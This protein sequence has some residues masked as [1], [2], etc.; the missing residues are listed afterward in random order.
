MKFTIWVGYDARET[1][2]FAVTRHSVKRRMSFPAP[3]Y[4]LY[5]TVLREKG[6]YTRPVDV[7]GGIRWDRISGAPMSTDHANA[8]F[9][10]PALAKEGWALFMDG[11][12]LALGNITRLTDI[13]DPR[14]A[15]YCVHH[16]HEPVSEIKMDG[17]IQMP[18]ARKNWSSFMVLNCDHPANKALTPE[19]ANTLPGRD[20]HRFCWLE[21]KDI[22]ELGPEWNFLIG[23]NDPAAIDPMVVH[24]TE[25]TPDMSGYEDQMFADLWR[26]ELADWVANGIR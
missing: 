10:M 20:L 14:K 22:G 15:L 5:P 13:L 11:D 9:L 21:D 4:G 18:Y 12:M 3:I 7:L 17:Q 6:I 1:A 23:I 8:R 16:R 26:A 24:F 2:A 25:G 19:L